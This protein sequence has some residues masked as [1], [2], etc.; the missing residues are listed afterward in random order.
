[1]KE[2]HKHLRALKHLRD[3]NLTIFTI[4]DAQTLMARL[5][6]IGSLIQEDKA[7]RKAKIAEL[8]KKLDEEELEYF[9]DDLE[10]VDKGLHHIMEIVGAVLQNQGHIAEVSQVV[11]EK[12]VPGYAAQLQGLEG[13]KEYELIN[14]VCL[15]CDCM[16]YGSEQM[17]G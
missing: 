12:I 1:M 16:E 8:A 13:K 6:Q 5:A 7:T 10:S 3:K 17:F 15:L 9:E 14:A 2:I 4:P 11:F